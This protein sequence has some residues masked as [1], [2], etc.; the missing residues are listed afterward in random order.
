MQA[1]RQRQ[2]LVHRQRGQLK[3]DGYYSGPTDGSVGPGMRK[4]IDDAIDEAEF[5]YSDH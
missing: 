2:H 5:E 3:K 1:L 4:A